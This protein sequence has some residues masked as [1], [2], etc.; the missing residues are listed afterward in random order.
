MASPSNDKNGACVSVPNAD[1]AAELHKLIRSGTGD[2]VSA[3]LESVCTESTVDGTR[4]II[5]WHRLVHDGTLNQPAVSKLVAKLMKLVIDFACTREEVTKAAEQFEATGSTE[6]FVALTLKAQSLFA[7][8]GK[9]TGE[10]GEILL[11]YL[12][13]R[14]LR[15][16]QILCKMP[17]KTNPEMHAHGAD[18]VHASVDPKSHHLRLH[19]GEAKLWEE[20]GAAV[21][22]CCESLAEMLIERP[23]GKKTSLRDIQ[24]L[25][26]FI[27]LQDA[28]MEEAIKAYL[29]PDNRLSNKV[30]FCGIALVGFDVADYDHFCTACAQSKTEEIA[31]RTAAWAERFKT[32]LEKHQLIGINV[33]A[34]IIPFKS[35]QAMRNEF[36][37]ALGVAN[38]AA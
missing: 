36:L 22:D 3:H 15:Y 19:W 10:V 35:V 8:K 21:D 38:A 16:P 20:F 37:K 32:A 24:L 33:D 5:R 12:A 26:D 1:L 28:R 2:D 13:E 25:R 30:E 7:K 9:K 18:G 11:Y 27:D 34:L 14:L 6:A 31:A 23:G 4:T 17:H 29:D